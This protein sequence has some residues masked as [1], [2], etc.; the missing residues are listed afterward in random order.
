MRLRTALGLAEN[1]WVWMAIC[2]QPVT[3]GLDRVARALQKFSDARLLV[4]GVEETEH[5]SIPVSRLA[6]RLGISDRIKWLGHREDVPELMAA[7][8]LFV[9]PARNDTTGAVILES[10]VNGLPVVTMAS[11]GYAKHVV[12]ADAGIALAPPF[13]GYSFLKALHMARLSYASHWSISA[14][15]Y[16][17]RSELYEG[18]GY[19]ADCIVAT[20]REK[21]VRTCTPVAQGFRDRKSE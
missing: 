21:L 16:G 6:R 5:K 9:H 3:K 14:S 4:V 7:A 15:R 12:A 17:K 2:V 19:A 13:R 1:D 8:D 18:R 11:C 20:A 10:V